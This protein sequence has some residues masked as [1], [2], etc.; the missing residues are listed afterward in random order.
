[1]L[2]SPINVMTG[3]VVSTTS[4]MT[5]ESVLVLPAASVAVAVMLCVPSSHAMVGI[6][7]QSP[8]SSV[9]VVPCDW[10]SLNTST[11]L[12]ASAVPLIVGVVSALTLPSLGLTML[13]ALGAVASI[14]IV[15]IT[16]SSLVLPAASVALSVILYVPS[17]HAPVTV[18]VQSPFPSAVVVPWESPSLNTSTVLSASAV[19]MIIG[20]PS[21]L[22]VPSLGLVML[23]AIGAVA[24]STH[25]TAADSSLVLPAA[26]VALAVM[27]CAPSDH[28]LDSVNVQSP[29]PSAMVVPCESP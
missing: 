15:V 6:N 14:V 19:P 29:F 12:S 20:V 21:V 1:M 13:G 5:V 8:F 4:V 26:S 22:T 23:G 10:P 18:N 9:V 2:D 24:S 11:T 27:L 3:D 16:D 7:V 28:A 25:V 17:D